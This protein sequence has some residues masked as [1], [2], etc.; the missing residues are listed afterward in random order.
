[1]CIHGRHPNLFGENW[2]IRENLHF[3]AFFLD[4]HYFPD[5]LDILDFLD[6][7]DILDF[8]HILDFL[9]F[10]D[11]FLDFHDEVMTKT[12]FVLS[13]LKKMQLDV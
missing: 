7:H 13:T 10:L 8:L 12:R 2:E 9:D 5:F 6:F 11:N 1:M 3:L 4:F